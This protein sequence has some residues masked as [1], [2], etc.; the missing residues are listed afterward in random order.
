MKLD[1]KSQKGGVTRFQKENKPRNAP[2]LKKWFSKGG[3]V[4]ISEVNGK[5]TWEYSIMKNGN[6]YCATYDSNGYITFSD[7]CLHPV[8][9]SVDIGKFAGDRGKDMTR[10]LNEL[11]T[12]YGLPNVPTGYIV[13][14]HFEN[15]KLLLVDEEFHRLFSHFGGNS[16]Y[17]K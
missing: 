10:F 1:Y 6:K 7:N 11:E 2:T 3:S 15:G 9:K 16:L 13:H 12:S 17:N 14:H 4:K 5:Q 8:I